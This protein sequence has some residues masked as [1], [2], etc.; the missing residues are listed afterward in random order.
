MEKE[1]RNRGYRGT[2]ERAEACIPAL[3]HATTR[4]DR[5]VA[6]RVLH[7]GVFPALYR[8]SSVKE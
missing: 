6:P 8:S 4:G 2:T 3:K 5:L 7:W 1:I